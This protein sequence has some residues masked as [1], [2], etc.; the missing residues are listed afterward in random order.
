MKFPSG[1]G[2]FRGKTFDEIFQTD[3]KNTEFVFQCWSRDECSGIFLELYDFITEKMS[4]PAE[5]AAHKI[6]C[7]EYCVSHN[8][9]PNYMSKY[10]K[11][12][13]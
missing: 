13:R 12:G 7:T 10:N 1:F 3:P 8:E 4:I 5:Q 11:H 6:R 2:D 9:V